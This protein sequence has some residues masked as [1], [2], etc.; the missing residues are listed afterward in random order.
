[1]TKLLAM[2]IP[3][4]FVSLREY[5]PGIRIESSYATAENFTGE[6]VAGYLAQE[7]YLSTEAADALKRAQEAARKEGLGLKIFDAYRPTKA[8]AFFQEWAKRPETNHDVKALYYPTFSRLE[9]FE[10]GYIAL[11][12]S[13]SRG[14]AVDLTLYTLA[15][16][17]DLD[18]GTR[19]DYFDDS[20][21][22]NFAGLARH[23]KFNRMILKMLMEAEGFKNYA[24]EWW[25]YSFRPEPFPG[26][27]FDFD[28]R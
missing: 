28:V 24:E 17:E 7:A 22:T 21:A 5:C 4:G 3:S 19:F 16:G 2:T 15:T 26:Q 12:S 14:S 1:M 27:Y 20:S 18:M 11:K 8:V 6:I 10:K 13:H 23:Q 25:H 9:L